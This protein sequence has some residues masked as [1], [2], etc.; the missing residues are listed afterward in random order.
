MNTESR[1][2]ASLPVEQTP[3]SADSVLAS[4]RELPFVRRA[5]QVSV[6]EEHAL[7]QVDAMLEGLDGAEW[8]LSLYLRA[9]DRETLDT[10]L[11]MGWLSDVDQEAVRSSVAALGLVC[12]LADDVLFYFHLQIRLLDRLAP[13]AVAV[14]DW[15]AYQ[16]RPGLW[17]R[18]AAS[19]AVPPHPQDLWT[20]HA[21]HDEKSDLVWLHTHGL[22]RCGLWELD[23]L[24]VP[25]QDVGLIGQLMNSAAKLWLD[26]G[27]PSED[28]PFLAG[29]HMELLWVPV[30]RALDIGGPMS[31]GGAADRDAIHREHRATLFVSDAYGRLDALLP[32]L[33]DHP[34]LYVSDTETERATALAVE[35]LPRLRRI[36]DLG[37]G[38]FQCVIKL[39]FPTD[40]SEG[41]EHIWFNV[42]GFHDEEV[43]ATCLNRPHDVS[44]LHEGSR[45]HYPLD[46]LSDWALVSPFGQMGPDRIALAESLVED[47]ARLAMLLGGAGEA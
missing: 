12:Q 26:H 25:R 18:E 24:P 44:G 46:M 20:I 3:P 22:H 6:R 34:V 8:P 37:G 35:R 4:L 1:L 45:D 17:L 28:T 16:A 2:E 40:H 15:S 47:P 36:L 19:T 39:A 23:A 5:E 27:M 10:H 7:W 43:D 42:H 21:V 29:M 9:A 11:S 30:D 32:V 13:D 31:L 38:V 41:R 14:L 33:H